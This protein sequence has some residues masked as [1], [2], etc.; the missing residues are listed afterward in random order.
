MSWWTEIEKL[1]KD[2]SSS[3]HPTLLHLALT[4]HVTI[5]L[6]VAAPIKR[7]NP[8]NDAVHNVGRPTP[9]AP[10]SPVAA[11][12]HSTVEAREAQEAEE[13]DEE[14]GSSAEE[15][16]LARTAP[17]T[18]AAGVQLATSPLDAEG[19]PVYAGTGTTVRFFPFVLLSFDD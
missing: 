11:E 7:G 3:S 15:E 5:E 14:G 4:R 2:T 12:Q 18:P 17:S 6:P 16:E 10:I 8:I 19:L 13:E 9:I 1:T